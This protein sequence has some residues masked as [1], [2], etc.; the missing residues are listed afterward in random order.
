MTPLD[1]LYV[2]AQITIAL[3]LMLGFFATLFTLILH[4]HD[5]SAQQVGVVSGLL[6][7]L[8]TLLALVLQSFFPKH[9]PTNGDGVAPVPTNSQSPQEG[10]P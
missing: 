1:T 10:K 8:P 9:T 7:V 2:R 4:Y 5:M 6:T 3:L